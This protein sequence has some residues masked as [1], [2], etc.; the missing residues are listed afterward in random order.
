MPPPK[1]GRRHEGGPTEFD[2]P[3]KMARPSALLQNIEE[4]GILLNTQMFPQR[5][6]F[7]VK[8]IVSKTPKVSL[9]RTMGEYGILC[10]TR[11]SVFSNY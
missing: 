7:E 5:P 2:P 4:Y 3:P 8:G 6:D 9:L 10:M 11:D 1:L